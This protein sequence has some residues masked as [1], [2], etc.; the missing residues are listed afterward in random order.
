MARVTILVGDHSI[1]HRV[2][3]LLFEDGLVDLNEEPLVLAARVPPPATSLVA[4]SRPPPLV[5]PPSGVVFIAP[6]GP[7]AR[8]ATLLPRD[9]RVFREVLLCPQ[10]F[11]L[12]WRHHPLAVPRL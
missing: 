11:E 5:P 7:K 1:C 12:K 2:G 9:S 10:P 8:R 4:V 3:N 6:R